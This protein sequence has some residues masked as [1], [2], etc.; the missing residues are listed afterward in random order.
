MSRME[1]DHRYAE[2]IAEVLE[3]EGEEAARH[4][5]ECDSIARPGASQDA[6]AAAEQARGRAFHASYR[7]F[8]ATCDGWEHFAWGVSLFGTEDLA[9]ER[10]AD[11]IETLG[12]TE[13]APEEIT[14]ALVIG[15]N[16]N[17]A[18]LILMVDSG[19]VID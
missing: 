14:G 11:A 1:T 19:E 7:A 6:I 10:Y 16:E 12:Y 8:L 17:D 4:D 2:I 15:A 18:T 9:G 5:D 13:D 3:V